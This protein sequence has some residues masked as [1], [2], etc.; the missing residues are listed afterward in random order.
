MRYSGQFVRRC[1][2]SFGRAQFAAHPAKDLSGLVVGV[3]E[4]LRTH[5]KGIFLL[6]QCRFRRIRSKYWQ[7]YSTILAF[8]RH[9]DLLLRPGPASR[10][11]QTR[12]RDRPPAANVISN[13][14]ATPDPRYSTGFPWNTNIAA[15]CSCAGPASRIVT[16]RSRSLR[17]CRGSALSQATRYGA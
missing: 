15:G 8:F 7:F 4:T 16:L 12:K 14:S 1:S 9:V 2:D 3:I 10:E 11:K 5:P 13:L 17:F 6:P